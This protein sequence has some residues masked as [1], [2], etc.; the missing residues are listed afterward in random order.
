MP[1]LLTAFALVALVLTI[2]GLASG[3]VERAPLSFPI[4]FL[5]LGF[6][7]ADQAPSAFR[8]VSSAELH[9][10]YTE[11]LR[12]NH[13]E[14]SRLH[15]SGRGPRVPESIEALDLTQERSFIKVREQ[16]AMVCRRDI[17]I[18]KNE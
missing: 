2:A 3:F 17:A 16:C 6:L 14:F 13:Q 1:D 5:G 15:L 4:V 18:F 9:P 12:R 7:L 8:L 11:T 10:I